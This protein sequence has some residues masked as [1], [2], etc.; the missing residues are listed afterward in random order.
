GPA[1]AFVCKR[2][3]GVN[4]KWSRFNVLACQEGEKRCLLYNTFQDSQILCEDRDAI[5]SLKNKIDHAE[6]LTE[7]EKEL[8]D[9]FKELGFVVE[10]Q[11]D[12]RQEF[13]DWFEE[14]IRN[15]FERISSLILTS[16]TCNL[17]C[18]YCFEK[19]VL[20]QGLNMTLDTARQVIR[21]NQERIDR[22]HPTI[23]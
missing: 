19:D 13:L 20:D 17:R 18:P 11:A 22:Y 15:N 16:R 23:M 21:W 1:F 3:K 6:P 2:D 9:G 5:A 10:D 4:M 12:E 14:K 8:A 7:N